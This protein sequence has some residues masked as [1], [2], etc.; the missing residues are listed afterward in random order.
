[1]FIKRPLFLPVYK[2]ALFSFYRNTRK[3]KQNS[4]RTPDTIGHYDVVRTHCFYSNIL[5]GIIPLESVT[6]G[7]PVTSYWTF[8]AMG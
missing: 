8:G 7:C 2:R 6:G 5:G 3:Y 4:G 1:M